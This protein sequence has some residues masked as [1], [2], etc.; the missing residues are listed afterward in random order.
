MNVIDP[1]NLV[2]SMPPNV[3][4]PF[5]TDVVVVGSKDTAT[6]LDGIA[7]WLK[8]LS[9]TVGMRVVVSGD[10]VSKVKSTGPILGNKC[11]RGF[12]AMRS[13]ITR[14]YRRNQRSQW[15]LRQHLWI[16]L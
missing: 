9:V 10:K 14:G 13:A 3:N 16:A 2:E 12:K 8:R 6:R 1:V 15:K 5:L 7:C 11:Q 4:S